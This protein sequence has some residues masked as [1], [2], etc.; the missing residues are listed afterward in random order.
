[1]PNLTDEDFIL[2]DEYMEAIA[3]RDITHAKEIYLKLSL[4]AKKVITVKPDDLLIEV[5]QGLDEKLV[6]EWIVAKTQS[7]EFTMKRLY[8]K[9]NARTRLELIRLEALNK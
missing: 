7:D 3:A 6:R 8:K 1:M 4:E 2:I 5:D 9:A